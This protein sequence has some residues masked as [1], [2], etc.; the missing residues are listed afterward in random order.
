METGEQKKF[1]VSGK[2]FF[3]WMSLWGLHRVHPG[4]IADAKENTCVC[5]CYFIAFSI[6]LL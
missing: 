6:V 4:K 3:V 1:R 5:V 2:G